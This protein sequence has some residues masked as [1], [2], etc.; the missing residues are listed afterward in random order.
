MVPDPRRRLEELIGA[1]LDDA[2]DGAEIEELAAILAADGAARAIFA[3][4]LAMDTALARVVVRRRPPLRLWLACAAAAALVAIGLG[5]WRLG[6]GA[7]GPVLESGG[8]AVVLRAGRSLDAAAAGR[9]RP[10]DRISAG[11]GDAV[12]AW[13][14][15]GTRATLGAGG[16]LE[17]VAPGPAKE[18]LLRDGQVTVAAGAQA[19]SRHLLVR[20]GRLSVTVVG[21]RFRV[22]ESAGASSVA[23]EHGAV[24]VDA[25]DG[26]RTVAAGQVAIR[27]VSKPLWVS[28]AG[29]DTAALLVGMPGA[30]LDA[31]AWG[32]DH[33]VGW[34][35]SVRA[36]GIAAIVDTPT[37][38][39][40]QNPPR[41][42]GYAR[43]LPD[44]AITADISLTRQATVALYL[45]CR[46]PDGSDWIGNY[47]A[48]IELPAGTHRHAWSMAD[49]GVEKGTAIAD[50]QGARL[51]SVAVCA[52]PQPAGL[53]VHE[54]T[55]GNA[56]ALALRP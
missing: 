8:G 12:I 5:L 39:R 29:E 10:A 23:V 38:E 27:P 52:W 9:L 14:D 4:S 19:G 25:G 36:D 51:V 30:R 40:V 56:G 24:A 34:R 47:L 49:L 6:G 53:V 44:L 55:V 17:I 50:A 22:A 13:T 16:S 54:V 28:P 3:R 26:P 42:Q 2:L 11:A 7:P 15:E 20:T 45:I 18:L 37:A 35:G 41:L 1:H 43:L 32:A 48:R 46:R 21:T 33:G 31:A